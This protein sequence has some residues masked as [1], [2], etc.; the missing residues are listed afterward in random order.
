VLITTQNRQSPISGLAKEEPKYIALYRFLHRW[1]EIAIK[2]MKIQ[3][4]IQISVIK[5]LKN[6]DALQ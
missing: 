6:K 3:N 5:P 1:R 2:G 4:L